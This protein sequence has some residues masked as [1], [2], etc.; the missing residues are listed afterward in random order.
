MSFISKI[1]S[2]FEIVIDILLKSVVSNALCMLFFA[3][4]YIII[5]LNRPINYDISN[6]NKLHLVE[7]TLLFSTKNQFLYDVPIPYPT[8]FTDIESL[9]ILTQQVAVVVLVMVF[10]LKFLVDLHKKYIH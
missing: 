1:Y 6:E 7:K 5:S 8:S 9:I 3:T 2:F 4:I 10:K